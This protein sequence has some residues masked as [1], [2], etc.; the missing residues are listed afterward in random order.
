MD[1]IYTLRQD[2]SSMQ[3]KLHQTTNLNEN[4]NICP[5]DNNTV[6]KLKVKLQVLEKENLSL[7]EEAKR[8]QNII[9]SIVDQNV[10]LLKAN[11]SYVNNSISQHVESGSRNNEK[12][13]ENSSRQISEKLKLKSG[14]RKYLQDNKENKKHSQVKWKKEEKNNICIAGDSKLKNITGAGLSKDQTVKIRPHPGVTTVDMIDYIKPELRHKPDIVILHCG[15][16]DIRNDMNTVKK[17]K[18]LFKEIEEDDGSTDI[19]ISGLIQQFDRK[20]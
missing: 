15:T 20:H 12:N 2:V 16:N 13:Q 14:Q 10:E 11:N 5:K 17:I 3:E 19:V 1:E 18:K 8:K 9:R 4:N 6:D 7:K